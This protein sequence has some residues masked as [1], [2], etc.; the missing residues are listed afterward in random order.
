[1]EKKFRDAL[2]FK[3]QTGQGILE[4]GEEL[5]RQIGDPGNDSGAENFVETAKNRIKGKQ[6]VFLLE[7]QWFDFFFPALP[8]SLDQETMSL[9]LRIGASNG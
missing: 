8:N 3:D 2:A 4:E 6:V 1:L 9:F 5:Q 7:Q